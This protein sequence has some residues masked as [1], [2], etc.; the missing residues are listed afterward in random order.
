MTQIM[1][2][3]KIVDSRMLV[4]VKFKMKLS[5]GIR[6][7]DPSSRNTYC[8]T[9]ISKDFSNEREFEGNSRE[10]GKRIQVALCTAQSVTRNNFVIL[11][12][13]QIDRVW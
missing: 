2:P 5:C 8:I 1:N 4:V 7:N 3:R 6:P 13:M 9:K 10:H 11:A 12:R